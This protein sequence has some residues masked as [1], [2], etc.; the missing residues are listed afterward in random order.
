LINMCVVEYVYT[1]LLCFVVL[2]VAASK[3]L[4]GNQFFG[5]AIGL[6]VVAGGYA[7]GNISGGNMNPSVSLGLAVSNFS[8]SLL[9]L[10]LFIAS[11]L[12]GGFF[13]V[14]SFH[15]VR[16]EE[17]P[18]A[19][20]SKFAP[21][22]L[23]R[24]IEGYFPAQMTAEFLGASILVLTVG[25]NVCSKSIGGVWSIA[26]SLMVMIFSLGDVS[27]AHFNP[28]V[29]AA[30]VAVD[31]EKFTYKEAGE[32]VL[33][34]LAG[35]GAGAALYMLLMLNIF[36]DDNT[37]PVM[38]QPGYSSKQAFFAEFVGT[39]LLAFVVLCVGRKD[40]KEYAGF[41]I[42]A[43]I[44]GGGSAMGGISGGLLNPAVTAGAAVVNLDF[45]NNPT[46]VILFVLAQLLGGVVAATV[47]K[48]VTHVSEFEANA[49]EK[50]QHGVD[51]TK[52]I[53]VA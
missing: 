21:A 7:A 51:S 19:S 23:A 10:P 13:S 28:A 8:L 14:V 34:Q 38:N 39:F 29:T 31:S 33:A 16:P 9:E 18:A 48:N 1:W 27:G 45:I 25:L 36:G 6:C 12:A 22:E 43:C 2:N 20:D 44:V 47:Y 3:S 24:K 53:M 11:Q 15:I 46:V 37:F 26:A 35:G 32:Y 50:T 17:K 52:F 42:G 49:R 30:V 4:K 40:I 5:F 41:A